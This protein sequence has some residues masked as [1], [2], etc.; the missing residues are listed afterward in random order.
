MCGSG[1]RGQAESGGTYPGGARLDGIR[2]THYP[3]CL[4]LDRRRCG[5]TASGR[6]ERGTD[7]G[8]RVRHGIVCLFQSRCRRVRRSFSELPGDRENDALGMDLCLFRLP[9]TDLHEPNHRTFRHLLRNR[10]PRKKLHS[11][12]RFSLVVS[13]YRYPG[14]EMIRSRHV[15]PRGKPAPMRGS[16]SCQTLN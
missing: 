4:P 16:T 10:R 8:G 13:Y 2:G 1:S 11:I 15:R 12:T 7:C 6:L 14:P 5:E 9:G 3:G